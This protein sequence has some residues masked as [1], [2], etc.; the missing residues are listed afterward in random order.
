M[1]QPTNYLGASIFWLYNVLA[2]VFTGTTVWALFSL[3]MSN[4]SRK[5]NTGLILLFSALATLS[6]ATISNNMLE[7]LI[8]SFKQWSAGRDPAELQDLPLALWNW[9][10]T[11]SLFQDFGE[12]IVADSGR[13]LWAQSALLATLSVFFFMGTEGRHRGVP[14]LWSFFCLSQILPTSFAQNL[15]Y[16]ALLLAPE[17]PGQLHFNKSASVGS[18]G[19]YCICLACAQLMA[20]TEKLIP[21]ILAARIAL[22]VPFFLK[23]GHHASNDPDDKVPIVRATGDE[24]QR[25]V[26][27]TSMIMTG[28]KAYQA[29]Q[30]DVSIP[31]IISS[32]TSHPAVA[33]LGYDFILSGLSFA[34]WTLIRPRTAARTPATTATAT[35][36]TPAATS[37]RSQGKSQGKKARS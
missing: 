25:I 23:G 14:Y 16:I 36:A 2:L 37:R 9:S 31:M 7:V 6:F 5:K 34:A 1:N 18:A 4:A 22:M 11:S 24:L 8:Q 20:G 35:K 3:Y 19:F 21:L 32:L 29:V 28:M 27:K 15:F 33:S 26:L 17:K 10:I 13:F 12:A 30:E